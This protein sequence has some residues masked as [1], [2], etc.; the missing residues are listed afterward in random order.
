MFNALCILQLQPEPGPLNPIELV[1]A[2]DE[3]IKKLGRAVM[4]SPE[5]VSRVQPDCLYVL[6]PGCHSLM[7]ATYSEESSG[8]QD[9]DEED[10]DD[11]DDDDDGI[12]ESSFTYLQN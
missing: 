8:E 2:R 6:W 12:K 11:D 3:C 1:S 5:R 10:E 9:E 4:G 7:D